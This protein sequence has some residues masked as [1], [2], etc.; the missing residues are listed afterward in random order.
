MAR[1]D[2]SARAFSSSCRAARRLRACLTRASRCG[3]S[4]RFFRM[5]C[6][7]SSRMLFQL[8]GRQAGA[9]ALQLAQ[10]LAPA[11]RLF[12]AGALRLGIDMAPQLLE[13]PPG[14]CDLVC[15]LLLHRFEELFGGLDLLLPALHLLLNLRSLGE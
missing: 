12:A 8:V 11:Q 6:S 9:D 1:S 14:F 13:Q 7:A 4:R 2:L 3:G 10:P 15:L 5:G